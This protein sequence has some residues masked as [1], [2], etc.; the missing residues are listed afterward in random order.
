MDYDIKIW[1]NEA[2]QHV[3][4]L[5]KKLCISSTLKYYWPFQGDAPFVDIFAVCVLCLSVILSCLFLARWEKADL[6]ALLNVMFSYVFVTFPYG[7]L[8]QACYLIVSI[9]DLCFLPFVCLLCNFTSQCFLF[10]TAVLYMCGTQTWGRLH[11]N[12]IDYNYNYFG[13]SWLLITI[14]ITFF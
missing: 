3:A 13:I 12:V 5:D 2:I 10:Y 6:L 9:L 7:V 14:T 8:G 11:A 4:Y 1:P